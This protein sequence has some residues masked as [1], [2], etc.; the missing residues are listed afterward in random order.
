MGRYVQSDP[1]GL[2][3][4]LNTYS[5]VRGN[6]IRYTDSRGLYWEYSQSTGQLWHFPPEGGAAEYAGEGYAGRD[7]GLNNPLYQREPNV[8]PLPQG[9]YSIAPIQTN[10]TSQ[11]T[12]LPES[13][14]LIPSPGTKMFDRS[15]FL[16]HGGNFSTFDSSNGCLVL[17]LDVRRKVGASGDND[18]RVVP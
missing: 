1:I 16:F 8:G 13:M 14:R 3:A 9:N 5:Y 11:G 7:K 4:G 18:L 17:P 6:P 15:G 10:V 12:V 2:I